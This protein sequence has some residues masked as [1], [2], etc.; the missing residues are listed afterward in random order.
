MDPAG[1]FSSPYTGMGNM[2][3]MGVDPNGEIFGLPFLPALFKSLMIAMSYA[4]TVTVTATAAT[5][6]S[7]AA[8]AATAT[9][10]A[11]GTYAAAGGFGTASGP[12][13]GSGTWAIE[14]GHLNN[15]LIQGDPSIYNQYQMPE[16]S[17]LQPQGAS[18]PQ[19][20]E[21][22]LPREPLPGKYEPNFM[23]RAD[24][25]I[26][27]GGGRRA[28]MEFFGSYFPPTTFISGAKSL[29]TGTNLYDKKVSGL[30]TGLNLASAIPG[31]ALLK[32]GKVVKNS[33]RAFH[34]GKGTAQRAAAEG[35]QTLGQTRAGKNLYNLTKGMEYKPGSE[36]YNMWSRLSRV[37]ARGIPD[38]STV[39][40]FLNSPNPNSI[41]NTVEKPLL[42]K[43]G[44]KIIEH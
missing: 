15:P 6:V 19:F 28:I 44:V 29:T 43:K 4:P 21:T 20:A 34:S 9:V 37:Y 22:S 39:H 33:V 41:W 1:Q 26:M 35:F 32:G 38:G 16:V 10:A 24:N 25:W 2:P 3:H 23:E 40:V 8:I 12:N 17:N 13:I 7:A 5:S 30:E 36:A 14:H 18:Q 27:R 11:A 31:G 42:K